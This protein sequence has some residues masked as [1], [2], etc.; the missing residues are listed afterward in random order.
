MMYGAVQAVS[1]VPMEC[2]TQTRDDR[3]KVTHSVPVVSRAIVM[4][5]LPAV[6]SCLGKPA[7][8]A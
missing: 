2:A 3:V 7:T 5:S 6:P 4:D 8:I 1:S